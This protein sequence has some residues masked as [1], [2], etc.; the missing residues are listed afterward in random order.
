MKE[1]PSDYVSRSGGKYTID[2]RGFLKC[3]VLGGSAAIWSINGGILT[4]TVFGQ[5]VNIRSA[6]LGDRCTPLKNLERQIPI[7]GSR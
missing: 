6:A 2:R 5:V 7:P 3:A 4:S 1:L